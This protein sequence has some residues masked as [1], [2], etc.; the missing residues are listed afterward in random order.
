M[1]GQSD[2]HQISL[3]SGE[4][5]MLCLASKKYPVK[6]VL[7]RTDGLWEVPPGFAGDSPSGLS[8]DPSRWF[9]GRGLPVEEALGALRRD[10]VEAIFIALHGPMGEDGTVQGLLEVAGFPYT[11]PGVAAAAITMDKRL[12]KEIFRAASVSTPRYFVIGPESRGTG[13]SMD[14]KAELARGLEKFPLP[15]ILKP[16]RLGSSVGIVIARS[17]EEFLQRAA[18]AERY[19]P[20]ISAAGSRE[21]GG[22]L[23]VEEFLEGKELS[24]G[25]IALNGTPRALPPI[26]I[27]PVAGEFFDFR[28]KYTPGAT[29]EIC[30]APVSGEIT[31][32]V[33]ELAVRVHRALRCDPL[34]RSDFI[35][36]SS[37]ALQALEINTIPGMTSN[38]LIPLSAGKAGIDLGDLFE[39]MVHHAV[40]RSGRMG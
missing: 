33:Q 37:G 23:L 22:E 26:E 18:E 35:L 11:G 20:W 25:V 13:A 5:V 12:T 31:R 40:R 38:S 2:E 29:E 17:G 4:T 15:W 10:G 7:I 24:C 28:A 14:W 30:P 16:N 34:S 32:K 1:G 19:L 27:R 6:P 21:Q 9:S 36:E 39:G 8:T 3:K